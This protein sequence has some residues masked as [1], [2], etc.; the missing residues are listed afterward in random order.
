MTD[1]ETKVREAWEVYV[2]RSLSGQHFIDL[3][4]SGV[5]GVRGAYVISGATKDA[6]WS[7]ALAFTEERLRQ[8]AEVEEEIALYEEDRA[9][10]KQRCSST[11]LVVQPLW[12]SRITILG[13]TI[14]ACHRRKAELKRGMR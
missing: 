14:D 4:H 9:E 6:A 3:L 8:I 7:A 13:R 2:W 1:A 10:M 5:E 12:L 11:M